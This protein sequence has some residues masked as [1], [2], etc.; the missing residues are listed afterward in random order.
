MFI[1]PTTL[2]STGG[3]LALALK[4]RGVDHR[5][6]F[7]RVGLDPELIAIDATRYSFQQVCAL[8]ELA[9]EVTRDEAFGIAAARH[10]KPSALGALGIAFVASHTLEDAYRRVERY[11]RLVTNA[12]DFRF[13]QEGKSVFMT[14]TSTAAV[15][16]TRWAVDASTSA[17]VLLSRYVTN[18]ALQP[19]SLGLRRSLPD[20][21]EP[22]DT[23]F[24]CPIQFGALQDALEFDNDVLRRPIVGA[25]ADLARNIDKV[26]EKY[27]AAL[28][29]DTTVAQASELIVRLLPSGE[30]TAE[31][32]ASELNQSLRTLKRRLRDEGT[33]F[34]SLVDEVRCTFATDY[35]RERRHSLA[36]VAYL[37]GFSDQA[38]F[39]RAFKRWTDQT[40][41]EYVRQLDR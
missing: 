10:L 22:W 13:T 19:L 35:L 25:S 28:G 12:Y 1:E 2:A 37:V 32:I 21:T 11:Y 33:N 26:A 30:V 18:E 7:R 17:V 9:S 4:E 39:T 31:N 27:L 34:R 41:G 15:Q 20:D 24:R 40:P 5:E 14:V 29:N 38:A 6:L 16:P 23:L 36:Q 3:A 8:W